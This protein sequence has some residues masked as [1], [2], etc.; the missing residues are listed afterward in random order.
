[1]PRQH[2]DLLAGQLMTV[3]Y[4]QLRNE[5]VEPI[6]FLFVKVDRFPGQVMQVAFAGHHDVPIYDLFASDDQSR[7]F[8]RVSD[9]SI[10]S[11]LSLGV[12]PI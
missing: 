4:L 9:V 2:D 1:L 5:V 3:G 6:E 7:V 11:S 12:R 8:G 10:H